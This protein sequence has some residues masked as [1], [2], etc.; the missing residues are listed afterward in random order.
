MKIDEVIILKEN[1]L[2][3][4]WYCEEV[5]DY[6][7]VFAKTSTSNNIDSNVNMMIKKG[8]N[9]YS[10]LDNDFLD[11]MLRCGICLDIY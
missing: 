9:Y 2:V 1:D 11:N 4:F 10:N 6:R 7:L 3:R 5:W 8:K